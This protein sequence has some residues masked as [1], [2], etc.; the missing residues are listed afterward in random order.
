MHGSIIFAPAG[1][2]VPEALRALGRGG[3][4]ALA[5]VKMTQIPRLDYE[6]LYGERTMRS[7]ANFSRQD[8]RDSLS[9]A[10]EIPIQTTVRAFAL[11]EANEA[12]LALKRS[13]IS[14]SG[15]LV[16]D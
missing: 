14:G 3:T 16:V 8:T 5:G 9:L 2:L 1:R 10:A 15:V 11:G 13:E 4:L 7:V 6:L 12:L